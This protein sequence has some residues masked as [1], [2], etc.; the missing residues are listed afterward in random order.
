MSIV[1]AP[2]AD[3]GFTIV[4]N[5]VA[6]DTRLSYRARGV[7]ISILSR[8]D[9]WK[10]DAE[11]LAAE[12]KEGR[13][14][15][16]A[17]LRELES[18]GYI[19]RIKTQAPTGLWSTETL[20]YEYPQGT[21][22]GKPAAEKPSS[23]P[24]AETEEL[25]GRTEDGKPAVGFPG[26]NRSTEKKTKE[27]NPSHAASATCPDDSEII[28]AEIIDDELPL[29]VPTPPKADNT[30]PA[31][32]MVGAYSDAIQATGGVM[33][34]QQ[35]GIIGKAAKRLLTDDQLEPA[36][37]LR[38]VQLAGAKRSKDLD[39]FLGEATTA[40]QRPGTRDALRST[41]AERYG[42]P[43]HEGL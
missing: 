40:Y 21:E 1:R 32:I 42:A 24:P 6:R 3:R 9:N 20:V 30:A 27:P 43:T 4:R 23:V 13:D 12:G 2:R 10:T 36:L 26:P 5:D 38:A 15:I 31:Q 25:P 41:W 18:V 28:D 33:T 17:V 29:N 22:D 34:K 35:A 14:A 16:R 19:R 11:Q 37:V 7:L 39:R 8:P